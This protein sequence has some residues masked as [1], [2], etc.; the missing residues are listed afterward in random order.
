MLQHVTL[1][2]VPEAFP[3]GARWGDLLYDLAIA[4][5]GAFAFYLLNIRVPL[6][7]DRRA[8]YRHIGPMVGMIVNHARILVTKLNNAANIA[9][10]D[11]ENTWTNVEELCQKIGPN[12]VLGDLFVGERGGLHSHTVFTVTVDSMRRTQ[13]GIEKVL[14]FSS[15]IAS[16]LI[17]LLTAIETESHFRSFAENALMTEKLGA[18]LGNDDLSMW[19]GGI[20]NYLTLVRQVEEY[21]HEFI[22]MT[23]DPRPDLIR[24]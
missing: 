2:N 3:T 20:Y 4:Y 17:D 5:V 13:N 19:A 22:S 18:G 11:R 7:R 8:V 23:A 15:Y 1:A 16:D 9:P 12:T 14:A 21:G 24:D 6:R 10:T